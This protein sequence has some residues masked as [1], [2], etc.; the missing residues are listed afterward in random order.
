M[1]IGFVG[2][3]R[4]GANMARRLKDCGHAITAV[5][6]VHREAAEALATELGATAASRLAEVTA[7]SEII[8]TVVTDD[9]AMREIFT[10]PGDHLL[11]G[12]RG[13]VFINCATLTPAVHQEV[14]ALAAEAG[15]EALEACMASSIPQAREGKLYL[16]C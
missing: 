8:F 3:G 14:A 4:M 6:D 2:V 1:K 12:A 9:A 13:K 16:M 5:Y 15:A 10:R 11:E 7:A